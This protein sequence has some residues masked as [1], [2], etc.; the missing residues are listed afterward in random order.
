MALPSLAV[1]LNECFSLLA[2]SIHSTAQL[3]DPRPHG[4]AFPDDAGAHGPAVKVPAHAHVD[5][6]APVSQQAE[7]AVG[8]AVELEAGA[9]ATCE[10]RVVEGAAALLANV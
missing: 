2:S 9:M 8:K 1:S 6:H 5:V 10:V 7:A 3:P 4:L